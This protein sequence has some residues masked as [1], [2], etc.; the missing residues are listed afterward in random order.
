MGTVAAAAP[1]AGSRTHYTPVLANTELLTQR[2]QKFNFVVCFL[3]EK[4]QCPHVFANIVVRHDVG[5]EPHR[6]IFARL[7]VFVGVLRVPRLPG[8][9]ANVAPR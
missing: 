2:I 6:R 4:G 5:V 8:L 9:E 1:A 3:N 7:A